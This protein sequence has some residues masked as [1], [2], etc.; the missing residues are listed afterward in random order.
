[1][2]NIQTKNLLMK[3]DNTKQEKKRQEQI[4]KKKKIGNNISDTYSLL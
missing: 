1:M 2:N 4:Q 3:I